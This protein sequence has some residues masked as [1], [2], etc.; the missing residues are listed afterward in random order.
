M[1][2]VMDA[3]CSEKELQEILDL[4]DEEGFE[5]HL[6]QGID[7][8]I[9][10]LIGDSAGKEQLQERI[11][12]YNQ[13]DKV[14]PVM[15][16]YK[17]TG[18]KFVP[19]KTVIDVDGVKIGGKKP[20]VMAGPCSVESEEQILETARVVKKAG[21]EVLR[22]GAFKPRTSPYSFQGLGE[23]GLEL[24]SLAREETGLKI[25]TE[26]MDTDHIDMV[27]SH[28]DIIQIGSRNMKNYA[29]LKEIGRLDKP[30]MLKRGMASTV[31]DWL[32]AAEYIM[33]EGNQDVML[34]ERGIKTF[35]DDTRYTMDLSA[36]PLVREKSHLPVIADPSHGTGRWELVAP[37]SRAAVA[38]GADGLLIEVHPEPKNALSDG[39][40]SLKPEKFEKLMNELEKLNHALSDIDDSVSPAV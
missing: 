15:E 12:S 8:Q 5:A 25:I 33:S 16:P 28:T 19:E 23:R 36:I 22:G 11:N 21:A 17:L 4:I 20:V 13:V 30:V 1:I 2:V 3:D 27:T 24:L 9:V 39:P 14:I 29:L 18:W 40:Q 7:K 32:L 35:C 26:L 31:K 34:C 6:S 10:G 37:M 38:G